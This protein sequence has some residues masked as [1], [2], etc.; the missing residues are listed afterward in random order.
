M[1]NKNL[2]PLTIMGFARYEKNEDVKTEELIEACL[3]W[4]REFLATQ[5]GI[6]LHCFLGN[7][8]G[9]FADAIMAVDGA[10]LEQMSKN[11]P[12][13]QSSQAFM[14]LLKQETITLTS[15]T[16]LKDN[17][18]APSSFSCI[19]FGTFK[20]KP[21]TD[22][23]ESEMLKVSG[24]IEAEYLAKFSEP[25]EHIMGRVSDDTYSEIAFVETLGSAREIC[26]GYLADATC[27]KL[28]DMFDLETTDLDFWYVLA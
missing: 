26:N 6:A 14:S 1:M 17:V 22:F 24:A 13:A 21:N 10:A 19:E 11:H 20:T 18:I 8:K 28:L 16:L 9:Q 23:S 3:N 2:G 27:Q 5:S 15:N 12:E 4:R 25:R 7:L